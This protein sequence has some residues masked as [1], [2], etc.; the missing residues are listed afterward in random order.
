M[1]EIMDRETLAGILEAEFGI[2]CVE[3]LG[4]GS[5]V[6]VTIV[7]ER[8]TGLSRVKRQQLVYSRLAEWIASGEL[9]AVTMTT[10]TPQEHGAV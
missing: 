7:S 4:E 9:H 1:A 2:D 6:H 3:V 8:F 5:H 10:H